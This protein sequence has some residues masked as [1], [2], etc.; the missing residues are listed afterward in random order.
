MAAALTLTALHICI[1]LAGVANGRD[2]NSVPLDLYAASVLGTPSAVDVR[3][4]CSFQ[5]SR[6]LPAPDPRTVVEL[7][8]A[9]VNILL[10]PHLL[11]H[12]AH[13]DA[14]A[15]RR[16][17]MRTAPRPY[18]PVP[19]ENHICEVGSATRTSCVRMLR[20]LTARL[21]CGDRDTRTGGSTL[22]RT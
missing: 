18:P 15:K 20:T 8:V 10:S 11:H 7:V 6:G 13:F 3:A 21:I 4:R 1:L 17:Y 2:V 19:L 9:T 12:R 16:T 14:P 22:L 5:V